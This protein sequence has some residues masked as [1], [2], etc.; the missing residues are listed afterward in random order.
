MRSEAPL[1]LLRAFKVAG[2][3]LS[4]KLAADKLHVTPPAVSHQ[5]KQL[6][7]RI[8][9]K[10]FLRENRKLSF[11]AP[12]RNYWLSVNE[13]IEQLD[14]HTQRVQ[15]LYGD[16][17]LKVSIMPPLAMLII[18]ELRS[19]QDEY[20]DLT[21]Y[22]DF[23][24]KNTDLLKSEADIAIRFGDGNW[25]ELVSEKLL[26]VSVQPIFPPQFLERYKLDTLE[27]L[28]TVPLVNMTSRP[29]S[30]DDWFRSR[31]LVSK[32]ENIFFVDDYPAAIEASKSLG[33]ALAIMPVEKSLVD[34]GQVV[35]PYESNEEDKLNESIYAVYRSQD[36][37]NQVI[38]AFIKWVKTLLSGL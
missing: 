19:F 29:E 25:S 28:V 26:E 24:I 11:T 14:Q 17:V 9:F 31:N 36:E 7:E 35:A 37:G 38:Q 5:I 27:D 30:W 18:K 4:F 2:D 23:N 22:T 32:A 3:C 10:L 34:S 33:A 12:G 20:P 21:L 8:G 1:N 6:E 16:T 15:Q 13:L